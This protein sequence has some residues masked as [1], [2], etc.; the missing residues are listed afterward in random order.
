MKRGLALS[1]ICNALNRSCARK[2]N[3]ALRSILAGLRDVGYTTQFVSRALLAPLNFLRGG[4]RGD[5]LMESIVVRFDVKV[6]FSNDLRLS[7]MAPF[8]SAAGS[9]YWLCGYVL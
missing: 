2:A 6:V 8:S 1:L 7:R 4:W 9:I 5:H 3:E